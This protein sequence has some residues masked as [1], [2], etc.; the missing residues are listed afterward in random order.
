MPRGAVWVVLDFL[1]MLKL[2]NSALCSKRPDL[3]LSMFA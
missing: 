1:S 3:D 2:T